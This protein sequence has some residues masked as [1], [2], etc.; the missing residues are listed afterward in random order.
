MGLHA[1]F[2]KFSCA[3]QLAFIISKLSVALA[4]QNYDAWYWSCLGAS[5]GF[6]LVEAYIIYKIAP[7]ADRISFSINEEQS[8][9]ERG[10][11]IESRAIGPRVG[12]RLRFTDE[13]IKK[14][15]VAETGTN[16]KATLL[17]LFSFSAPDRWMLLAA[18]LCLVIG[19]VSSTS[20]PQFTGKQ[21]SK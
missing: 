9:S 11:L 12:G 5:T 21:S 2:A 19:A 16:K 13:A 10:P 20:L 15:L 14:G 18:T 6:I 3:V 7:D 4:V 8:D 1:G 17:R